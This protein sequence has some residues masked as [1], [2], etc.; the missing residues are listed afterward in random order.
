M[1]VWLKYEVK[2]LWHMDGKAMEQ[3]YGWQREEK[4]I[5]GEDS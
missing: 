2:E 3:V 4:G 1:E 5:L